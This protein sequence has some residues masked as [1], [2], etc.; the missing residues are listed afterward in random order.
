MWDAM[1]ARLV[2]SRPERMRSV[3]DGS[4]SHGGEVVG[5]SVLVVAALEM[6][7]EISRFAQG[8]LLVA[9]TAYSCA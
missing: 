6:C 7:F 5:L 2:R 9:V 8:R 3:P 4:Q 1:L